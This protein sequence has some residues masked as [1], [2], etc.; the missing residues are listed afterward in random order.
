MGKPW[1][2]EEDKR[3]LLL[4]AQRK[5]TAEI[6]DLLHKTC[7]GVQRRIKESVAAGKCARVDLK[8]PEE[9]VE[10]L[11]SLLGRQTLSQ[12]ATRMGRTISTVWKK[13]KRMGFLDSGRASA[14]RSSSRSGG[15]KKVLVTESRVVW[16]EVCRSPVA[17]WEKHFERMPGCR[18]AQHN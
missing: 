16:C 17:N 12:I 6:A 4:V 13:A 14:P 15:G 11:K 7:R 10:L 3:L 18:G 5:T 9:D 8:W 2:P 1:K